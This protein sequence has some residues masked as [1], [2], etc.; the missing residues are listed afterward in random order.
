MTPWPHGRISVWFWSLLIGQSVDPRHACCSLERG[1][2][3][4]RLT[5]VRWEPPVTVRLPGD[6]A[7]LIGAGW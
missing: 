5:A 7:V 3:S 6:E 2:Q 4:V 1:H